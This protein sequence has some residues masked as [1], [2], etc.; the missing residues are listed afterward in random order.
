MRS[1]E[2]DGEVTAEAVAT[3]REEGLTLVPSA[4][5]TGFRGVYR[6]GGRFQAQI[7]QGGQTHHLGSFGSAE[8]AALAYARAASGNAAA[9]AAMEEVAVE[10]T[11]AE[12]VATA[13]EEGLTL[14]PGA[15]KTG[16]R[17]VTRSRGRF[18]AKIFQGGRRHY[19]GSFGTAEAAALAYARRIGAAASGE[20]AAAEEE[21]SEEGEAEEVEV[22]EAEAEEEASPPAS[23]PTSPP[24][25]PPPSRP[26][27]PSPPAAPRASPPGEPSECAGPP[28][29]PTAVPP[30]ASPAAPP[31]SPTPA[32]HSPPPPPPAGCR[33]YAV[34]QRLD[35]SEMTHAEIDYAMGIQA[36][37]A[38]Y[39]EDDDSSDSSN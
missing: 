21:E 28:A 4:N 31:A 24:T 27:S 39:M 16:Y 3:A 13:S 34:L 6:E 2:P 32:P 33:P 15:S 18:H 36:L 17:G 8:A 1:E 12:A 37:E 25:T 14:V 11:A 10:L 35:C 38:L 19:L 22:E 23:P 29:S 7:R 5:R 30:T 26:V 9:A 20:A